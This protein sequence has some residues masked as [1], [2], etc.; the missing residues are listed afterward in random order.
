MLNTL[1]P[2]PAGIIVGG[3][4][5]LEVQQEVEKVVQDHNA[6]GRYNLEF[7]SIP[8]GIR[9]QVGAAGLFEWVKDALGKKFGVSW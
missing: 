8:L 2:Y 6:A 7:V 5:S 4:L 9:E 3:G 1:N